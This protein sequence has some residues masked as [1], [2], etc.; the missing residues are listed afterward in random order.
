M[1]KGPFRAP[2]TKSGVSTSYFWFYHKSN[3]GPNME[4]SENKYSFDPTILK[5]LIE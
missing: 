4:N 1:K 5:A 3:K 2:Q